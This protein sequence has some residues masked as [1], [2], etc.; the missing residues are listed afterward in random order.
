MG[1]T[2][3]SHGGTEETA[4]SEGR[5]DEDVRTAFK[6]AAA[7]YAITFVESGMVLGLGAGTTAAIA[8]RRIGDLLREG[9]LQGIVGVPSS[10]EVA[11]A[12]RT[13]GIPLTT[14]EDHPV[15]DLTI[16]G[17]DEVDP[18]L[19]LIKGGG[20]ALLHEKIVA[21]ASRRE[22][23]IVDDSKLSPALGTVWA[24]PV[25]VVAF[26]GGPQLQFL[27]SLGARVT[28]RRAEDGT[29]F[30]TDSGNLILDCAF[31]PIDRPDELAARLKERTGIVDHGLFLG[32]TTDLIVAGRE[33]IRHVT[34]GDAR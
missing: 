34:P 28:L 6:R 21:Q 23:I 10:T 24:V 30:R 13:A 2:P 27:E 1:G 7:E 29:P 12:A 11:A 14:L 15:L 3:Q 25:E 4:V 16:D 8:V 22:I 19:N 31:G 5:T 17:A 9:R 20:G 26:G 32:L 18:G 33:G